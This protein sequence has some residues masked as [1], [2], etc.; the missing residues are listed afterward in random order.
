[1]M[2][3]RLRTT[4][5]DK[6]IEPLLYNRHKA[7]ADAGR[8][9]IQPLLVERITATPRRASLRGLLEVEPGEL[10]AAGSQHVDDGVME[11]VTDELKL[12]LPNIEEVSD[13]GYHSDVL[14]ITP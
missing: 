2:Q 1:M 13:D 10:I 11:F 14:S 8:G 12:H 9:E 3:N 5:S 7:D 4:T 6:T